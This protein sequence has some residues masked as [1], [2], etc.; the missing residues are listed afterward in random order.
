MAP[1]QAIM[2]NKN[3]EKLIDNITPIEGDLI[4]LFYG[5]K[6]YKNSIDNITPIEGVRFMFFFC[7]GIK[8]Y[9]LFF[10]HHMEKVGEE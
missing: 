3:R 7:L 5:A 10:S 2:T 8:K 6:M 4:P 1:G 9:I